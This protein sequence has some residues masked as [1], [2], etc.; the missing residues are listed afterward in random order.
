MKGAV[1]FPSG[2]ISLILVI[3]LRMGCGRESRQG[4]AVRSL[5][6]PS[7]SLSLW[8][9]FYPSIVTYIPSSA[10]FSSQRNG[11]SPPFIIHLVR[12]SAKTQKKKEKH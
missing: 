12:I 2:S 1:S 6:W 7:L 10:S 9:N 11:T 8:V 5:L 3:R 4:C